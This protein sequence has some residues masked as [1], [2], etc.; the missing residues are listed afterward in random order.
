MKLFAKR[1]EKKLKE[2]QQER[3]REILTAEITIDKMREAN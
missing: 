3:E 1:V 2:F